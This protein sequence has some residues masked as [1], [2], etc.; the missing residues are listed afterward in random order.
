MM[1]H[2]AKET[3]QQKGQEGWI[4]T[5][6]VVVRNAGGLHIWLNLAKFGETAS[7]KNFTS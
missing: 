6:K 4:R 3:R 5:E 7:L 2:S 1:T